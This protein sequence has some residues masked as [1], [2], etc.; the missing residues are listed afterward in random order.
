M[1]TRRA[2]RIHSSLAIESILFRILGEDGDR[3]IVNE[4]GYEVGDQTAM[5]SLY[6]T[7]LN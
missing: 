6:F 7:H 1:S 5:I 4:I 3:M 2:R